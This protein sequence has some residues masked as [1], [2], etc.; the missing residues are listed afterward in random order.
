MRAHLTS[1]FIAA[2]VEGLF[3]QLV[4]NVDIRTALIATTAL[5]WLG[6]F[7]WVGRRRD[8]PQEVPS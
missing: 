2:L 4:Q 1:L 8:L 7:G 5:L 6:Y 3:R